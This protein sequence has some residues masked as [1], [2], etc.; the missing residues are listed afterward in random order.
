MF[1]KILQLINDIVGSNFCHIF[2]TIF[3][4]PARIDKHLRYLKYIVLIVTVFYAW[5]TAG[6]W[7]APYDP[8][9]TYGHLSEGLESV[10]KE[11]AVGFI[12][13]L[14]TVLDS[15]IHDRFFCKYLCPMGALYGIFGKLSPF[16]VVRNETI[17]IHCGK[18]SKGSLIVV[19][20][21]IGGLFFVV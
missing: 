7:M 16:K 8:W 1:V 5:K 14:I 4:Y 2:V 11:S 21:T 9:S 12:V 17:C 20:S 18:C 19:D 15:L 6:L 13:L 10:W 3:T